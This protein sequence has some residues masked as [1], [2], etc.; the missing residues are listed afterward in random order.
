ML[1]GKAI[2][3]KVLSERYAQTMNVPS[4]QIKNN[5]RIDESRPPSSRTKSESLY[6]KFF[7][8]INR[9]QDVIVILVFGE[10]MEPRV[11]NAPTFLLYQSSVLLLNDS[12]VENGAIE[13]T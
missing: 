11:G 3:A 5:S 4:P 1:R 12:G 10:K 13:K 6:K 7:I 2:N 9:G 8:P